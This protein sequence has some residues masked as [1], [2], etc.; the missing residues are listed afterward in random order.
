M[1][2]NITSTNA[3][4]LNAWMWA[5][6]FHRLR[7]ELRN[8]LPE[9]SFLAYDDCYE[10]E[11]NRVRLRKFWWSGERSAKFYQE[12]LVE[13]IAPMING[14][15]EVVFV[16]ESGDSHTGLIINHGVVTECDVKMSLVPR[17]K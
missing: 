3:L 7:D 14:R 4:V 17:N 10:R 1:S 2:Y 11:G 13:R 6:D 15:V 8:G 12:S 9:C 16:W 5:D